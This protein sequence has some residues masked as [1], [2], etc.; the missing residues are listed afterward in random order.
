MTKTMTDSRFYMWRALFALTHAD[1]VVTPEERGF[2]NRVLAEETFNEA[3]KAILEQDMQQKHDV[4]ALFTKITDQQDRSQFFHYARTLVWCDGDFGEEEQQLL[5]KLQKS[6]F[7]SVDFETLGDTQN[8]QLA[9]EE[10]S[11]FRASPMM[12]KPAKEGI[13]DKI[14]NL[15]GQG[16]NRWP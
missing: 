4:T 6:H 10:V 11:S 8:L 9:E 1:A 13:F 14:R 7:Q 16:N 12:S 2:M 3:Q 5:L 15:F